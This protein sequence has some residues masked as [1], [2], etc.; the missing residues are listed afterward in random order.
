MYTAIGSKVMISTTFGAPQAISA[1]SNADPASVTA[2]G[3]TLLANDEVLIW[4]AW[5]DVSDS[6][7]R[8]ANPAAGTFKLAELDTTDPE[9]YPAGEASKGN[10][11]KVSDWMEI[12]NITSLGNE[13]GGAKTIDVRIMSR[14]NAI[15]LPAGFESSKITMEL[16]YDPRRA[17]QKSLEKISRKLSQRVGIKILVPGGATIYGYGFIQKSAMPKFNMDD[18]LK[19]DATISILGSLSVYVAD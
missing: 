6:I 8:V 14:R 7:Y 4:N 16:A 3:H 19:V 18:I 5:D 9:W 2:A 1:I 12:G 11:K 13:G 10:A 17:D 15:S